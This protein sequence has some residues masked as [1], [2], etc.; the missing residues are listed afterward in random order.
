VKQAKLKTGINHEA[1]A[2]RCFIR[3]NLS[4]S[5]LKS[6]L[7]LDFSLR[8]TKYPIIIVLATHTVSLSQTEDLSKFQGEYIYAIKSPADC[9]NGHFVGGDKLNCICVDLW[10]HF[11]ELDD[12]PCVVHCSSRRHEN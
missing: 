1:L 6:T 9:M 5:I 3:R 8:R 10:V 2:N 7:S 11:R 12:T 4:Y